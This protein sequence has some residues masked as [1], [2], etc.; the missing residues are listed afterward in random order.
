MKLDPPALNSQDSS[1]LLTDI[2]IPRPI[3]WVSTVGQNGVNNLAPFS[4]YGMVCTKPML[5]SFSISTYRA[6]QKKDTLI[7]IEWNKEFVVN[8][9]TDELTDA[10]N[11]TAPNYPPDVSEFAKAGM[12][13]AKSDLVKPPRVAESPVNMECRVTQILEFGDAPTQSRFVIGEVLRVHV[14]DDFYDQKTKRVTGLRAI[15][16]LGGDQD[17]Y[18][19]GLDTFVLKRPTL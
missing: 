11:A 8:L 9:V 7:N 2:V 1:H 5:V 12:T 19:R 17:L 3:A 16:R 14:R 15:G 18:C 4:A 6:G 13:P 10:M